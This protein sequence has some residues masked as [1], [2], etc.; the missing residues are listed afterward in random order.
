MT[1]FSKKSGFTLVEIITVISIIAVLAALTIGGIRY[2]S[3]AAK[4]NRA[5]AEIAAI[6]SAV[7][8]Y[9]LDFGEPPQGEDSITS[10]P[11]GTGARKLYAALIE[12]DKIYL[13]LKENQKGGTRGNYFIQDPYGNP[14]GYNSSK[15]PSTNPNAPEVSLWSTGGD[16]GNSEKWIKNW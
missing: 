10:S 7:S 12:G 9:T 4:A 8:D 6:E 16:A 14:Y 11:T 2:V 5:K 3:G 13:Q 15:D 1:P